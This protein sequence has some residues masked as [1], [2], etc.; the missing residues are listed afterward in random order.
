MVWLGYKNGLSGGWRGFAID[1][2]LKF[3]DA[4]AFE[5]LPALKEGR[6]VLKAREN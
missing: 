6:H 3:G 1:H 5:L 2:M 4:V